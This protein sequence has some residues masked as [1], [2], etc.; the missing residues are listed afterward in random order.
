MSI[1]DEKRLLTNKERESYQQL[2]K[3][4]GLEAYHFLV[5]VTEDQ[6]P[7]DMNDINYFIILKVKVTHV[8]NNISNTYFSQL[9][10]STW[11]SEFQD[12]LQNKYYVE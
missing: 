10:S 12:D 6:N 2:L 8:Q 9:A 1:V 4:Y 7:I 5:E 11:V 3:L